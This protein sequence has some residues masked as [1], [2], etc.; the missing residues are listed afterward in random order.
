MVGIGHGKRAREGEKQREVKNLNPEEEEHDFW[1]GIM[2]NEESS[3][4]E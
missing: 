1:N 4:R 3:T 2:G